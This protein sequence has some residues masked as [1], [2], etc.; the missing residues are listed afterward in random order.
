LA[1]LDKF[2]AYTPVFNDPLSPPLPFQFIGFADHRSMPGGNLALTGRR[3]NNTLAHVDVILS[4]AGL[5]HADPPQVRQK[6]RPTKFKPMAQGVGVDLHSK[7]GQSLESLRF[8][9][10]V[11]IYG[12][13]AVIAGFRL[14]GSRGTSPPPTSTDFVATI[15]VSASG[16]GIAGVDFFQLRIDDKKNARTRFFDYRGGAVGIGLPVSF[17][18]SSSSPFPFSTSPVPVALEDFEGPATHAQVGLIP[19]VSGPVPV[20]VDE[21]NLLGPNMNRKAPVIV[22]RFFSMKIIP[23]GIPSVG[24]SLSIGG[25]HP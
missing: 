1:E 18:V 3:A 11:D 19:P 9:R 17:D 14:L 8:W 10:R 25:L 13:P 23:T 20:S 15:Q 24:I 16:G 2:S 5:S 4:P 12:P 22:L 7:T 21:V 6:A